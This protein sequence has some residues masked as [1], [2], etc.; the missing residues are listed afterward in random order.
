MPNKVQAQDWL[1]KAWKVCK[2][3]DIDILDVQV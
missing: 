3:L 1:N 2:I